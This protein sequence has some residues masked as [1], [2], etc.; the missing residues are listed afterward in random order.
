MDAGADLGLTE[1]ERLRG[2]AAAVRRQFGADRVW[3]AEAHGAEGGWTGRVLAEDSDLRHPGALACGGLGEAAELAS[4]LAGLLPLER[5]RRLTPPFRELG[6]RGRELMQQFHV[7][8]ALAAA[9]AVPG[10]GGWRLVVVDAC[11]FRPRWSPRERAALQEVARV[12]ARLAR[13]GEVFARVEHA[14][15]ELELLFDTQPDGVA[16]VDGEGYVVRCN[17]AY[18]RIRGAE[19]PARALGLAA[20][21]TLAERCGEEGCALALARRAGVGRAVVR[22]EHPESVRWRECAVQAVAGGTGLFLHVVRDVTEQKALSERAAQQARLESLGT[23]AGGVAHEFNNILMGMRP[24]VERL[25]RSGAGDPEAI[26]QLDS[27]LDRAGH[28]ARRMLALSRQRTGL[29]AR[30]GIG[31]AL[32]EVVQ[33]LRSTLPRNI[34]VVAEIAPGLGVVAL[35]ATA[36]HSIFLNLATNARDAMPDGGELH[37]VARRST[38]GRVPRVVVEVRDTG[39]GICPADLPRIFD[40]FFST[41]G[42]EGTG[43]GL[44]VVHRLVSE[45]GGTVTVESDTEGSGTTFTV[46]L[47]VVGAEEAPRGAYAPATH[48]GLD[49]LRVLL[50][51]DEALILEGVSYFL[52][53]AGAEVVACQS[54][55]EA[56]AEFAEAPE[57]FDAVVVDYG[58]PG[59]DG[60]ALLAQL[61]DIRPRLAAVLVSGY[62]ETQRF[63]ALRLQGVRFFQK[64]FRVTELIAHL[65]D[66]V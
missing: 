24:A 56:L 63:S 53:E 36:V 37:I 32:D 49:G 11:S 48:A 30:S 9:A 33:V 31:A 25:H 58:L 60:C 45:A 10:A 26:R 1:T 47:P 6:E 2:V 34:R 4:Q 18:A 61:L 22:E 64:P 29:E 42:S 62:T 44:A 35:D 27:A 28:L 65:A 40:P 46:T 3:I 54:A 66:R 16:M 57:S 17:R 7:A 21:C 8:A 55:E 59:L 15:R 5:P 20:A 38:V 43:L 19:S 51:D 52:R 14:K 50:V 12:V 13:A 23:L 39:H 41:K